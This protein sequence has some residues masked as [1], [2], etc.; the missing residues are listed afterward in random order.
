MT[1]GFYAEAGRSQW[2]GTGQMHG[3]IYGLIPIPD[4]RQWAP[5]TVAFGL[6]IRA[7]GF[8]AEQFAA[9]GGAALPLA[10]VDFLYP[11]LVK[12]ARGNLW[13]YIDDRGRMAVPPQY[14]Y[15]LDFQDNGLAIVQRSDKQ[16]VIDTAGR[17]VVPPIYNSISGFSEGLAS[18]I[19][20][21]GFRVID[22][23]GHILTPKA[24]DFIGTYKSGRAVFSAIDT[25]GSS[26]YGYLDFRGEEAIPARYEEAGEFADGRAVVKVKD[27]E[28]AL[29]DTNG[30]TLAV[31]P[32]AFVGSPGEGLLAFQ[33]ETN[34]KY[35]YIDEAGKVVIAPRFTGALPFEG[36]RAVVNASED[37]GNRYGLI[38]KKGALLIKPEYNDINPLGEDRFAVGKAIDPDQPYIGSVY[39]LADGEGRFLTEFIFAGMSE[40]VRGYASVSDNRATYWID[41]SG[42]PV[43]SLPRLEGGGSM[44]FVGSLI[45]ADVDQRKSY[46]DL[47]G[48]LVWK[49]NATIPLKPPYRVRE[50]KYKPNKDYLV[51]YPQIEGMLDPE[52][53]RNA[54]R[55]LKALSAVKPVPPYAQLD[56]SYTGDFAVAFYRGHLLV[57]ELDGYHY[58]FGAAHGM[59]SRE[60][61]HINLVIGETYALKDLF[62]PGSPYVKR[63]SDIIRKQ[64]ATDPQY[65]YVFPDSFKE[66]SPTQLFYVTEDALHIVFP[67]YE[68]A[69]Y[70][71][72]FP[73]FA[74]PYSEL[75]GIIDTDGRFWKS[76]H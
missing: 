16:G 60:Y 46:Y 11:A 7:A 56:A 30:K 63:I 38:D 68:I 20:D 49:P 8:T 35:G 66:I 21:R 17:F 74:I 9:F 70:A 33:Q 71:V 2:I 53:E 58:P 24:Y 22:D 59:P 12:T 55:K 13:G 4:G 6:P 51:Y 57:L 52:A 47:S 75:A 39:A 15:A 65:S 31:Y 37:F 14:E 43:A 48:K 25:D 69:P 76:F 40:Y 44:K 26:R 3:G 61:V 32:Y 42:R 41:R 36:G 18:V 10:R 72:G 50:L 5:V 29:I 1:N 28:Y 62:K 34:G 27:R 23:L 67:P 19:D 73:T 45:S 64:I 54:N